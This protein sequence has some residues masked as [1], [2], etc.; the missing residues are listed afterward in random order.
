MSVPGTHGCGVGEE[1]AKSTRTARYVPAGTPVPALSTAHRVVGH[2][3]RQY[4]VPRR[5]YG[6]LVPGTA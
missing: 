1:E 2:T 6:V 4:G 5:G 3:L